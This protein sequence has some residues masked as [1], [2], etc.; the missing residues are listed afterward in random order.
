MSLGLKRAFVSG[1]IFLFLF[2]LSDLP[3]PSIFWSLRWFNTLLYPDNQT[4]C[5]FSFTSVIQPLIVFCFALFCSNQSA[6]TA[7]SKINV[8]LSVSETFWLSH[9]VDFVIFQDISASNSRFAPCIE[10][11]LRKTEKIE[12]EFNE[13]SEFN[14][15]RE[16][17]LL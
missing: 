3:F 8:D 14:L 10:P 1:F 5:P 12:T 9:C 6:V 13:L 15:W 2:I 7:V 4:K 11:R 16:M 17:L